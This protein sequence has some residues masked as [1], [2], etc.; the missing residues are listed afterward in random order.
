MDILGVVVE[1]LRPK[2]PAE[3]RMSD[4]VK[5]QKRSGREAVAAA[6]RDFIDVVTAPIAP[7]TVE[8]LMDTERAIKADATIDEVNRRLDA[9]V[10]VRRHVAQIRQIVG[11]KK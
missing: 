4:W 6:Q 7:P 8:E 11:S 10:E 1:K 5:E 3:K 2:S 9:Q